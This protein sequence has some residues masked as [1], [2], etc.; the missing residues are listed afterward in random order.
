MAE[1]YKKYLVS[2]FFSVVVLFVLVAAYFLLSNRGFYSQ[3]EPIDNL[4]RNSYFPL[5]ADQDSNYVYV[6][7]CEISEITDENIKFEFGDG[8]FDYVNIKSLA[9]CKYNDSNEKTQELW[10]IIG[11]VIDKEDGSYIAFG[12]R[13]YNFTIMPQFATGTKLRQMLEE[14]VIEV[15]KFDESAKLGEDDILQ[16]LI[17]NGENQMAQINTTEPN[18]TSDF[19]YY[20]SGLTKSWNTDDFIQFIKTGNPKLLPKLPDGRPFIPA[21]R[22]SYKVDN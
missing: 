20:G 1:Q 17:V 6:F 10:A 13:S 5:Y 21:L 22:V 18:G 4:Q 16:L 9:K 14:Y 2:A 11:A 3:K 19:V 15:G 8:Q 12:D 7:E